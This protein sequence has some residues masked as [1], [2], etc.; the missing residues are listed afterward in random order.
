MAVHLPVRKPNR[1][2]H[3]D[4]TQNGIYFITACT[5]QQQ[6]TLSRIVSAPTVI[7]SLKR[8]VSRQ[9]TGEVWQKGFYDRIVRTEDEYFAKWDYIE[10]NPSRWLLKNTEGCDS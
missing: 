3:Y 10:G 8:Y 6:C 4:D 7:G 2:K 5:Y 9:V 1:L